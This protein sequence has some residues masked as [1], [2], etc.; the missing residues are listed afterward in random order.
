MSV[1]DIDTNRFGA[2]LRSV[3][4]V[5]GVCVRLLLHEH[6]RRHVPLELS[7]YFEHGQSIHIPIEFM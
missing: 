2:P 3:V 6:T 5:C 1:E 7:L 4:S